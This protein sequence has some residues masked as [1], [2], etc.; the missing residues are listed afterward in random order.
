MKIFNKITALSAMLVLATASV[1]VAFSGTA[2]AACYQYNQNGFTTSSTPVFNNICGV[3]EGINNEANFVRIRQN[4]NGNDMNNNSNP[5]YSIGTLSATCNTGTKFD[6]WNYL[7]NDASSNDNPN[8]N[9]SNPSAVAKNVQE[10]LAA[11]FGVGSHFNFSDT[12]TASN[13]ATVTD[14]ASLNCGNQQ[15][16]LSIVPGSV[17]IYSAPYNSWQNLPT[18]TVNGSGA[19]V[20]LTVGSPI[21]G[22]GQMWGCWNYRIVI[23][24]QVQTTVVAP[25]VTPPT[26]NLL[27]LESQGQVAKIEGLNYT[28]NNSTITGATINFGNGVSQNL[29]LAQLQSLSPNTPYIYNYP[30][31]GAYT[32]RA[33]M[34]TNMGSVTSNQCTAVIS[35]TSAS[36]STPS[37]P[38][39]PPVT[40]TSTT[41]TPTPTTTTPP[42]Q[43]INTGPG[44]TIAIFAVVSGI[45]TFAYRWFIGRRYS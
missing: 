39:T 23:V 20:P 8:T 26:C 33:T 40:T 35:T 37:T 19:N 21:M 42:S 2:S 3:P 32:V 45:S 38:T 43:L 15:V 18:N 30:I 36:T 16:N 1:L 27:T 5:A 7:H 41:I 44:N 13:A 22:S 12:I 11:Q 14:S 31:S 28:A 29:S 17:H 34:Q 9:P 10:D 4:V 25:K 6:V 24:Y